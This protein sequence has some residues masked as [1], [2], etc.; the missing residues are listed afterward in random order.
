MLEAQ[1]LFIHTKGIFNPLVQIERLGYI[2]NFDD[3]IEGDT[4]VSSEPYDIDFSA[5]QIN[6]K[7]RKVSLQ[8]GQKLD[9]GGFL[10]GY[11]AERICN[12]IKKSSPSVSGVVVNIGGDIHT[13]GLDAHGEKFIFYI[14]NPIVE[15][16][17]VPVTLHNESL[18]TSGTYKRTWQRQGT[19][20]HHILDATG[21]QNPESDVVSASVVHPQGGFAE[22]YAKV[23]LS[24]GPNQAKH[25]LAD[26]TLKYVVINKNGAVINHTI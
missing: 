13:Q 22:A 11:L 6:H 5:T 23:V 12:E 3:L 7:T 20:V 15:S 19:L 8:A 14:H 10:K 26:Q 21:T 1:R 18:A 17:D 25:V 4:E 24:L 9:F 16:G 2:K